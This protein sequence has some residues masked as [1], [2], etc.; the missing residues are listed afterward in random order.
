[1][2]LPLKTRS[3]RRDIARLHQFSLLSLLA[4]GTLVSPL[5]AQDTTA[6]NQSTSKESPGNADVLVGTANDGNADVPVGTANDGNA[7]VPVGTAN[8]KA[9]EEAANDEPLTSHSQA[10]GDVG[11]PRAGK[12]PDNNKHMKRSYQEL[13]RSYQEL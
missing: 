13:K 3:V 12:F 7:D 9:K 1:M 8:E 2:N 4:M 11:A 10:N 5:A 6:A